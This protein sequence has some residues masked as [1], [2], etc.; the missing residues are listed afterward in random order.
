MGLGLA[1]GLTRAE[2]LGEAAFP[3]ALF[4]EAAEAMSSRFCN[5]CCS[6]SGQRP[7]A[8]YSAEANR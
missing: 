3:L 7:P 5:R 4:S 8:G 6:F 2:V 1:L